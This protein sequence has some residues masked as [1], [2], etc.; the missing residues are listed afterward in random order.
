MLSPKERTER[1]ILFDDGSGHSLD[2]LELARVTSSCA[3]HR[4]AS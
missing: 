1:A 3:R 2:T 4:A